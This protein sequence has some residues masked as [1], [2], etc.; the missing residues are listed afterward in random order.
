MATLGGSLSRTFYNHMLAKATQPKVRREWS[1][2][3]A[4]GAVFKCVMHLMGFGALIYAGYTI[5]VTVAFIVGGISCF[6]FSWIFTSDQE[7]P[8]EPQLR[9]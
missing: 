2:S 4:F 3:A 5:N 6:I 9:R 1:I 8:I 7:K